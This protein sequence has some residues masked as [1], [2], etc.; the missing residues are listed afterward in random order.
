MT[1]R[2]GGLALAALGMAGCPSPD[3]G[4]DV[5]WQQVFDEQGGAFLS[6]WGTSRQDVWAVGADARDGTGPMVVHFD[7]D[8]WTRIDSGQTAGDLWWVFGFEDGPI[9]MGGDG[10]V[11]VRMENDTFTVMDTPG[12]E[13]VFGIWGAT[14]DDVWAV[15]GASDATGGFAWRLSGDAWVP[16]PSL[17]TDV[18]DNAAVWK[19]FGRA[20]NDAWMVGSNGVALH[21]DG[22]TLTPGDTGV[23][24]SLFTV[25]ENDGLYAAVGG[26]AT[27]IIVER[28]GDTW[29]NVTP[30]PPPMGMAGVTLGEDGTGIAVGALG[31]VYVRDGQR[32]AVE[33]LGFGLIE[34]LHGS[35]IDD[36]GGLW[37]V[38]GQTLAPPLTNGVM[39][40]R[41]REVPIGGL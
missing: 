31:T 21:W 29:Q 10:G 12:T 23:G 5:R 1:S 27:G 28:S 20:A 15:G 39:I 17:P 41:G 14:P 11:I 13:T 35:W 8:A 36:E 40:H 25:H 6:V 24:S 34:N 9:Y 3:D 32:W 19:M 4:E 16:E 18:P 22:A 7:G 38:G 30:D 37:A 2:V 33:E 26:L